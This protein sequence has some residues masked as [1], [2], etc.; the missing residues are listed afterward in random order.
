MEKEQFT[1]IAD[2]LDKILK[3]LAAEAVSR[4]DREQE[5]IE[6][7]D[8]LDF[9]ASDIDRYLGKK[10]GY[11]SVVLYQLKKKKQ[12]RAEVGDTTTPPA[13]EGAAP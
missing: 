3:L 4:K 12:P 1:V 2:K 13:T 6:F 5:K 9:K 10:A 8:S 7:L 11:S